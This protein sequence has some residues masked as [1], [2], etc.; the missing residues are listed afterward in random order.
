MGLVAD[1]KRA[2]RIYAF[3]KSNGW[4]ATIHDTG[5]RIVFKKLAV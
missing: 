4:A 1:P 3:A 2:E 5:A